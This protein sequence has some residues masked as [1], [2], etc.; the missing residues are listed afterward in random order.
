MEIIIT[1]IFSED[2]RLML[3]SFLQKIFTIEKV[4]DFL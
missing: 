1:E 4:N 2:I 3:S